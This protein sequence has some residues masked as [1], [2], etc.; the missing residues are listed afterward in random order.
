MKSKISSSS[1][2]ISCGHTARCGVR[3]G[4]VKFLRDNLGQHLRMESVI[5][6]RG[7]LLR[8]ISSLVHKSFSYGAA[9]GIFSPDPPRPETRAM[10][11][12]TY[13]VFHLPQFWCMSGLYV[14]RKGVLRTWS[15]H[16]RPKFSPYLSQRRHPCSR[17][18]CR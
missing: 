10:L 9:V 16:Y 7:L 6:M 5:L 14:S 15:C 8:R 12:V 1:R 18:V 17:A 3:Q 11:G 2:L 13:K 4:V